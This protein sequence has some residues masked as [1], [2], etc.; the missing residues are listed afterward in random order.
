MRFV[1]IALIAAV[2]GVTALTV[3]GTHS[4]NAAFPGL[5]GRIAYS[6]GDSYSYSSAAI[7]S[8]NADGGSA[9]L[10]SDGAGVAAPSYSPNGARIA[11]D[12][13]GGIATMSAS[14]SGLVQLLSGSNNQES[15]SE[16]RSNYVVPHSGNVIPV[17]WIQSY[18]DEWQSFDHP[19]FSP[20]GSQLVVAEA[21]GRRTSRIVCAV[22]AVGDRFCSGSA[23]FER[24]CADCGAHLV[25]IDSQTGARI[26]AL[27]ALH[28]ER[29]DTKPA[30]S[31]SGEIAF[32]RSGGGNSSIFVIDSPGAAPQQVTN[33]RADRAPDFSP[34]GSQIAFSH[35]YEDIGVVGAGGGAVQLVPIPAP[36][37]GW[38]GYVNSPVFSP[39]GTRIAF[40]RGVYGSG[41]RDETGIF[42]VGLDGS[43]FTRIAADGFAPSWQAQFP[44]PPPPVRAKARVRKGKV[45]LN[46]KGRAKIGAIVCGGTPCRLRALSARLKAG[47]R[48]CRQVRVRLRKRLAPGKAARVGVK[49]YG[50]CLRALEKAGKGSLLV[51]VRAIDSLGKKVLKL[52]VRLLPHRAYGHKHHGAHGRKRHAKPK[53]DAK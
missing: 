19:S 5:N 50:K 29:R 39:D 10:L 35:G 17:A 21:S 16:W 12:R 24:E 31:A 11:F 9:T 41:G 6:S 20:D 43:G 40:R 13:E 1:V 7:W 38:G 15:S 3:S 49:V 52:K 2:T 30:Y 53:R 42:T 45:K 26:A 14:G 44:P 33:G 25:A 4:G 22:E 37:N 18:A 8:I 32:A 46:R 27:T 36:S 48:S 23:T 34:D 47:K 51:R 28:G